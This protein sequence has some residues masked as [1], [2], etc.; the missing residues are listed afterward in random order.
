M[1]II[2]TSFSF[3]FWMVSNEV[4]RSFV[5]YSNILKLFSSVH[6]RLLFPVVGMG[7]V[8]LTFLSSSTRYNVFWKS[9]V[10]LASFDRVSILE[11]R[12]TVLRFFFIFCFSLFRFSI[13]F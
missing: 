12:P 3:S 7:S 4:L 6:W 10:L 9:V 11:G 1:C 5:I 2:L 8:F 13:V